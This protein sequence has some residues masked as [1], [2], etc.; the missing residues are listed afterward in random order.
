MYQVY[1]KNAEDCH[2][3]HYLQMACEKIA[4][5][6]RLREAETFT[7]N[8][9]HSHTAFSKFILGFL[10]TPRLRNRYRSQDAKRRQIE[11]YARSLAT[12]IETLAPAVDRAN[13]PANVEYPWI[14]GDQ[15][16]VPIRHQ[17]DVARRLLEPAGQDFLALVEIAI[18][19]YANAGN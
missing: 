8:D 1:L 13:T 18:T 11:R 17:F 7:E 6:Y 9:L 19:E 15:V 2:R 10:K 3:L 4:K 14:E 16:F 5:A 12:A